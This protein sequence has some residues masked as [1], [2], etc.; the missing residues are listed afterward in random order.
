MGKKVKR[1]RKERRLGARRLRTISPY[2]AMTPFI[3][4]TRND[5][6]VNFTDTLDITDTEK[7]ILEQ[8]KN[9]MKGLGM[10]HIFIAG[11][12]RAVSQC[13]QLNRFICG[14]RLFARDKIEFVMTVKRQMTLDAEESSIKVTLNQ[15]DTLEDIYNKIKEAVEE[16]KNGSANDTDKLAA[17]FMNLPRGFLRLVMWF[18]RVCDYYGWLP[19]ALVDASPFHGSLIVTDVGS[20]GIPP[21][22]HHIYNFGNL[23]VFISFGT[24]YKKTILNNDGE[25]EKHSYID[26]CVV[27]DERICDGSAYAKGVSLMR[28][29]FK[30]P[31]TLLEAPASV[32]EDIY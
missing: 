9:G 32:E 26:Y 29:C 15:T 2:I 30:K 6:L 16:V 11:Y 21:V 22:F 13:P 27:I 7:F 4:P 20:L 1:T 23:P 14:Q 5:A 28:Q 3:M 31:A 24:K 25:P 18:L 12:V 17:W 10:L 19:K 8:R